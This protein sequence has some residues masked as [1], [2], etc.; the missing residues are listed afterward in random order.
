MRFFA[1]LLL[2]ILVPSAFCAPLDSF[3]SSYAKAQLILRSEVENPGIA[4]AAAGEPV[5]C[6]T[7][8]DNRQDTLRLTARI[9]G[10]KDLLNVTLRRGD[11][12]L[13]RAPSAQADPE[14]SSEQWTRFRLSDDV[15]VALPAG[16]QRMTHFFAFL[17]MKDAGSVRLKCSKARPGVW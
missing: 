14:L 9:A 2:S 11:R 16:L 10:P 6:D 5:V 8:P 7:S 12:T 17:D 1:G 13:L 15:R 3:D 4:G